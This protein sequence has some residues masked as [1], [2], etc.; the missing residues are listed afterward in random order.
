M[1]SKQQSAYTT[2]VMNI[3]VSHILSNQTLS[4]NQCISSD[5]EF[6][7]N[8]AIEKS[9]DSPQKAFQNSKLHLEMYYFYRKSS[10]NETVG[11]PTKNQVKLQKQF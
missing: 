11:V 7:L 8:L 5:Q 10:W 2:W 6:Q 4:Y 9:I 3:A 1:P